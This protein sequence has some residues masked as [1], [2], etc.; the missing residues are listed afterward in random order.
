MRGFQQWGPL[1]CPGLRQQGEQRFTF[2]NHPN[3]ITLFKTALR[4]DGRQVFLAFLQAYHHATILTTDATLL[5]GLANKGTVS[6]YDHLTQQHFTFLK[7]RVL[8]YH[9]C[10]ER[11][12]EISQLVI[13]ANNLETVTWK[14]K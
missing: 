2:T 13:A 12:T 6:T 10:L 7:F 11:R 1:S 5:Q 8:T 9:L 3:D 4:A 14:D